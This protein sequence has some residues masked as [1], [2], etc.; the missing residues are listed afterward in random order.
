[1][2]IGLCL[3]YQE[4]ILTDNYS[5]YYF[6]YEYCT[7]TMLIVHKSHFNA[8]MH[9]IIHYFLISTHIPVVFRVG[10]SLY[11]DEILLQ[12]NNRE[13]DTGQYKST[14]VYAHKR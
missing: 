5:F 3:C 7:S 6:I 9:I 8:I 11:P 4:I 13:P 10:A 1:M 14:I 12:T 2:E